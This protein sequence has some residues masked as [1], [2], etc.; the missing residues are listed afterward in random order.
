[1]IEKYFKDYTDKYHDMKKAL[2]RYID[3]KQDFYSLTG[4]KIDDMPKGNGKAMGFDDLL[5]NIEHLNNDYIIKYKKYE[6][7]R[8]RCKQDIDKLDDPI[9]KAIIEYAYLDFEDNKAMSIS[10]KEYHNKDYSL[11]YIKRLKLRAIE[12]FTRIVSK[13]N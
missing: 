9:S 13:S 12:Q 6:E 8:T 1:M 11:G 5:I 10:L 7:E 2:K 3:A 4:V